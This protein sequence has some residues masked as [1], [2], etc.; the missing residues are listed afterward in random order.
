MLDPTLLP[1]PCGL[2]AQAPPGH[3]ATVSALASPTS[4]TLPA[5]PFPPLWGLDSLPRT[6]RVS[7]TQS[8]TWAGPVTVWAVVEGPEGTYLEGPVTSAGPGD[9]NLDGVID[10]LDIA[11]FFEC[12]GSGCPWADFNGDGDVDDRDIEAFFR[13]V[14]GWAC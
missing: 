3:W 8:L 14:V 2:T 4:S 12:L 1:T 7:G 5:V 10:D 11:A 6:W 13:A 9:V